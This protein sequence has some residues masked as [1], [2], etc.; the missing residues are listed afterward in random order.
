MTYGTD[1]AERVLLRKGL[2]EM[3]VRFLVEKHPLAVLQ[4]LTAAI[5]AETRARAQMDSSGTADSHRA[6]STAIPQTSWA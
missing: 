5:G 2:P 4:T 6:H 1:P 3:L